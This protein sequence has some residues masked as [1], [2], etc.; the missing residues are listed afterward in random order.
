MEITIIV[1]K[2]LKFRKSFPGDIKK[3][4]CDIKIIMVDRNYECGNFQDII[5]KLLLE[6]Y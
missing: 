5:I 4:I 1:L 6:I 2:F 3:F